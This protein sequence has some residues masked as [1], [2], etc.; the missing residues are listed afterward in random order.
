MF[1]LRPTEPLS[2]SPSTWGTQKSPKS[3]RIRTQAQSCPPKLPG[4][5]HAQT[6]RGRPWGFHKRQGALFQHHGEGSV[7]PELGQ[8][9]G[10]HLNPLPRSQA[11]HPGGNHISKQ[12]LTHQTSFLL[13][14]FLPQ[15]DRLIR[16][17]RAHSQPH[18]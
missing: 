3:D 18:G 8:T 12:V 14:P 4:H 9:T 10:P 15:A 5:E 7:L 16:E 1:A 2:P 13:G 17:S 6:I 11:P